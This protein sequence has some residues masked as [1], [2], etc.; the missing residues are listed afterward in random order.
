MGN[1]PSAQQQLDEQQQL[2]QMMFQSNLPMHQ[3]QQ[4]HDP[5]TPA[6]LQP[7]QQMLAPPTAPFPDLNMIFKSVPKMMQVIFKNV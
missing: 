1:S 2:Q 7:S 6:I 3:Q 4:L 5:H